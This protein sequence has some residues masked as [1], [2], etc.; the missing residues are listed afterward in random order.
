MATK[1]APVIKGTKKRLTAAAVFVAAKAAADAAAEALAQAREDLL[2]VCEEDGVVEGTGVV[3]NT[4]NRREFDVEALADVVT[5]EVFDA[6]TVPKVETRAFDAYV[7]AQEIGPEA[8][9]AV[10]TV[11]PIR[12][13][14]V[15]S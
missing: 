15:K 11:K 10:V 4:Q 13:V 9:E 12:T 7:L 14:T 3:L 5:A 1:T 2:R 8:V 6:V